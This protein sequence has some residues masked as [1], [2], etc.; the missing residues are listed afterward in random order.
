MIIFIIMENIVNQSLLLEGQLED[1][2]KRKLEKAGKLDAFDLLAPLDKSPTKKHLPKLVD[3]FLENI[4]I[5]T[6]KDYYQ[7]FLE[8]KIRGTDINK[9]KKWQEFE[10]AV[11]QQRV[12]EKVD[13]ADAAEQSIPIIYEDDK[14]RIWE[15]RDRKDAI[16]L[17][18]GY[19]FCI[20]NPNPSQN[21]YYGYRF[22]YGTTF[23]FIRYK[24][25]SNDKNY[26]EY[27]DNYHLIVFE[28]RQ[29]GGIENIRY[30]WTPSNNGTQEIELNEF[31][32]KFPEVKIPWNQGIFKNRPLDQ[33]EKDLYDKVNGV[34]NAYEFKQLTYKEKLFYMS[35]AKRIDDNMWKTMD[36]ELRRFYIN[37]NLYDL[38]SDQLASL[39]SGL[40]NRY[41]AMLE[42]RVFQKIFEFPNGVD[43][44]WTP[45][46]KSEVKRIFT[47]EYIHKFL[48][49][50]KTPFDWQKYIRKVE[51]IIY[52]QDVLR[53]LPEKFRVWHYA[54]YD[55]SM[56]KAE[57]DL[58]PQK[59]KNIYL[60]G[61]KYRI[62][63]EILNR[64]ENYNL[65]ANDIKYLID[66]ISSFYP[67]I[68]NRQQYINFKSLYKGYAPLTNFNEL[69]DRLK[70]YDFA[71]R[72]TD[73]PHD[74]KLQIQGTKFEVYYNKLLLNRVLQK[75]P[76]FSIPM[77][78]YND[79]FEYTRDEVKYITDNYSR[80]IPLL[81]D[82]NNYCKFASSISDIIFSG[83][84]KIWDSSS[85]EQK[86]IIIKNY[87]K[88]SHTVQNYHNTTLSP[89]NYKMWLEIINDPELL[90]IAKNT[91]LPT[92]DKEI[93]EYTI[94]SSN[95]SYFEKLMVYFYPNDLPTIK[96]WSTRQKNV[97]YDYKED[98]YQ[99]LSGLIVPLERERA[100]WLGK[101]QES[102]ERKLQMYTKNTSADP[103][104]DTSSELYHLHAHGWPSTL[105]LKEIYT[106]KDA[107][108]LE[109]KN[110]TNSE[111]LLAGLFDYTFK[112][113]PDFKDFYKELKKIKIPNPTTFT[114]LPTKI[115]STYFANVLQ[116]GQYV[117]Y[118][119]DTEYRIDPTL[120][121]ALQQT[122]DANLYT[123]II[124]KFINKWIKSA[125]FKHY[126]V[127]QNVAQLL[128]K[129][130]RMHNQGINAVKKI[131]QK[132]H[133]PSDPKK[134]MSYIA[135]FVVSGEKA[136]QNMFLTDNDKLT[137]VTNFPYVD[138]IRLNT[139][140]N[141]MLKSDPKL[142]PQYNEFIS[143]TLTE[144]KENLKHN[145]QLFIY[146]TKNY[147]LENLDT[148]APQIA[149]L[150]GEPYTKLIQYYTEKN[151]FEN[152]SNVISKTGL[153]P[154]QKNISESQ[155][156]ISTLI[157]RS[158]HNIFKLLDLIGGKSFI[159]SLPD[160]RKYDIVSEIIYPDYSDE[161]I[162]KSMSDLHKLFNYGF[163]NV[164]SKLTQNTNRFSTDY[165]NKTPAHIKIYFLIRTLKNLHPTSNITKDVTTPYEAKN[166]FKTNN[167]NF[168]GLIIKSVNYG[169]KPNS[170]KN[171]LIRYLNEMP[172]FDQF[173]GDPKID[174]KNKYY[175]PIGYILQNNS[176]SNDIIRTML[177]STPPTQLP[178]WVIADLLL[179]N[180][181]L[182]KDFYSYLTTVVNS[183]FTNEFYGDML[184][185]LLS[186][187]PVSII[188]KLMTNKMPLAQ[189]LAKKLP[190]SFYNTIL[191]EHETHSI[192][193]TFFTFY[194][195]N[196]N[197]I[198][199]PFFLQMIKRK[200]INPNTKYNSLTI[201]HSLHQLKN[202]IQFRK[203]IPLEPETPSQNPPENTHQPNPPND[204]ISDDDISSLDNDE[205]QPD[206][207]KE[208]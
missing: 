38:T 23:F 130:S 2:A 29:I 7:R 191:N 148:F 104:D 144:L 19:T 181:L 45:H 72:K 196:S 17:G 12:V 152:L 129:L 49:K 163:K 127:Q 162:L 109:F 138:D 187:S 143:N 50:I 113:I 202:L 120:Y 83:Y 55:R 39:T 35:L 44:R 155:Q 59:Y 111:T 63:K 58:L 10:D 48:S 139:E 70:L 33:S 185:K 149:S 122:P 24:N 16:V 77:D 205:P 145:E 84:Q 119:N 69:P 67:F 52:M 103:R 167:E 140:T 11:D 190:D 193:D 100:L 151:T 95:L 136:L 177:M 65:S 175:N 208:K 26:S 79:E 192:Y 80:I 37:M 105:T 141:I 197:T 171:D 64:T 206:L 86:I 125:P 14:L 13:D 110:F 137:A 47:Q 71:T 114:Q 189:T 57:F 154:L 203:A 53:I 157:K 106:L 169:V 107:I 135:L 199:N 27:I 117:G 186:N 93:V 128:A 97:N 21:A 116:E 9:Y 3:F 61:S 89:I 15:V 54:T 6:I 41:F 158:Q 156:L 134:L 78:R 82:E 73:I 32:D 207:T 25:R 182:Y 131:P 8:S 123:N 164:I 88:L 36:N 28:I 179:A 34:Y 22:N 168:I 90:N 76:T 31:L 200:I 153:A 60:N 43:P 184:L 74:V 18:R 62:K 51:P 1:L 188:D 174:H 42:R 92:V 5:D 87:K 180:L 198:I 124:I 96:K 75:I 68:K 150:S 195:N 161:T 166:Q 108:P 81:K 40:K 165:R 146:N 132:I 194:A 142:I 91:C 133:R 201:S 20:S 56:S 176:P 170:L 46:E 160:N 173:S 126:S 30:A 178:T 66:N 101:D 115:K 99:I 102:F 112:N 98:L 4:S 172:Q 147:I 159:E 204:N 183:S 118:S 94:N 85:K 121:A